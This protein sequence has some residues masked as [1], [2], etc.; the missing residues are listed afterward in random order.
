ME[1]SLASPTFCCR[2]LI[3]WLKRSLLAYCGIICKTDSAACDLFLPDKEKT[4]CAP[5]VHIHS[6]AYRFP[7][8]PTLSAMLSLATEEELISL[9]ALEKQQLKKVADKAIKS[10]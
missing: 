4:T 10:D 3:S 5:L 6:Q 2:L 9:V 1:L 8:F 7:T